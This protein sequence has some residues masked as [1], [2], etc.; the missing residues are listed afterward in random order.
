MDNRTHIFK[1]ALLISKQSI[2]EFNVKP[3]L[4][5]TKLQPQ[6][7]SLLQFAFKSNLSGQHNENVSHQKPIKHS[8]F[9][10]LVAAPV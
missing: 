3:L 9:F 5:F 10:H 8:D 6:M 2:W 1:M 7:P 4:S